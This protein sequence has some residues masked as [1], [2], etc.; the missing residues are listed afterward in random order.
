[1]YVASFLT[2]FLS[3]LARRMSN[4][5]ILS[6]DWAKRVTIAPG[7]IVSLITIDLGQSISDNA[8][9]VGIFNAF[10]AS[11]TTNSRILDRSTA[12]PSANRE[13][14]V[15]PA[16]FSWISYLT[17]VSGLVDSKSDI[18]LPSPSWPAHEPNCHP[19]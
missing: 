9:V 19:P 14:G 10:N 17:F 8:L 4:V 5:P 12:F 15:F 3:P 6:H 13:Y 1:M 7:S 11:E 18:A 2:S 16:P